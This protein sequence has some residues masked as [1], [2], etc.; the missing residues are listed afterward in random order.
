LKQKSG[1]NVSGRSSGEFIMKIA[2]MALLAAAA[3]G[4]LTLGSASAMPFSNGLST[5]GANDVQ[6]VRL[7]CDRYGR[8][9]NTRRSSR[10]VRQQA[11]RYDNRPSYNRRDY[12]YRAE[13]QY[14]R[15][16]VGIGV[17]PLGVRVY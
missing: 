10:S 6:Q 4:A 3:F 7:V 1:C 13:R 12:G 9:Y 8:C 16:G 17:G 14:R 2:T 5:Q 11:R 15:P